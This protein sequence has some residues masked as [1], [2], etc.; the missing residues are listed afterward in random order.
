MF[1]PKMVSWFRDAV[2]VTIFYIGWLGIA[3]IA[4]PFIAYST[5]RKQGA[6]TPQ[7]L[8]LSFAAFCLVGWLTSL[9]AN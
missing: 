9:V 2:F 5:L 7:A 4:T 3:V 1:T 8:F 6:S